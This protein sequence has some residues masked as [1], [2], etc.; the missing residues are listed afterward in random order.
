MPAGF[1]LRLI[2]LFLSPLLGAGRS[3]LAHFLCPWIDDLQDLSCVVW[4]SA[5]TVYHCSKTVSWVLP[6]GKTI[7]IY[8]YVV[9]ET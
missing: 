6:E 1:Y 7:E 3:R 5:M 2:T 9:S 4:L 8:I